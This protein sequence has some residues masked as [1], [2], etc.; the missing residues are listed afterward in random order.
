MIDKELFAQKIEQLPDER[1]KELIQLKTKSNEEIIALAEHE[2]LRRGI[3]I[4][5]IDIGKSEKGREQNKT[6]KKEGINWTWVIADFLDGI[7]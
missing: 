1:L 7:S 4:D 5:S 3:D 2:A 6:K